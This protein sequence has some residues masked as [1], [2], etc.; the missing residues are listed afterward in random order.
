MTTTPFWVFLQNVR[1]NKYMKCCVSPSS[2][3]SRDK[4]LKSWSLEGFCDTT[5]NSGCTADWR[6][7]P[8]LFPGYTSFSSAWWDVCG[9]S[10]SIAFSFPVL[11]SPHSCLQGTC[12]S[13]AWLLSASCWETEELGGGLFAGSSREDSTNYKSPISETGNLWMNVKGCV[14]VIWNILFNCTEKTCTY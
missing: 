10:A 7:P 6:T 11:S 5:G 1:M 12:F 4:K 14:Y 2:G 13:E 9:W 3:K 8:L